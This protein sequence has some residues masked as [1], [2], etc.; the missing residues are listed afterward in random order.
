M[1][2]IADT[3]TGRFTSTDRRDQWL[4]DRTREWCMHYIQSDWCYRINMA[5]GTIAFDFAVQADADLF[6]KITNRAPNLIAC[7]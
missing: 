5:A 1:N 3:A 7:S 2:S 6:R 4:I